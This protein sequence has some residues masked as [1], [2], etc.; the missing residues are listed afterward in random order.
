[1]TDA[2]LT[3][4]RVVTGHDDHGK[5]IIVSDGPSP[6]FQ[7]R[8]MFAEIWNT[9]GSPARITAVEQRE[10]ND[11]PPQLAPP[12]GGSSIRV[13]EMRAGHR[14]PMHRTRTIDY[15]IVLEGEVFLVM[16]DSETLLH[17]GDIVVQRGTNHAWENRSD[18]PAR[19]VFILLAAEFDPGL[20]AAIPSME[21][22]P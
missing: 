11:R 21:L 10:P 2:R 15:G 9:E 6:Q 16:E 20:Q 3:V 14:S 7:D 17:Q 5:S 4:R 18:R 8:A 1:M 12:P 13:V 19:M 22:V